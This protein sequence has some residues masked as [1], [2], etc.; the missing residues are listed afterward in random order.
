MPRRIFALLALALSAAST[1]A[2]AAAAA[3]PAPIPRVERIVQHYAD[4]EDFM[5]AVLVAR[6]DEVLF[7]KAYGSANLEL[8]VP[9]TIDTKFRIGSVTKQ[10]TAAA[11]LLLEERGQL[12]VDDPVRK[13]YPD[14]PAAWDKI[15][16]T[17][18]VNH[19][20]GIPN[21]TSLEGFDAFNLAAHTPADIVGF[22]RDKPLEFEPGAEMRYSNSGYILLG[23]IIEKAGGQSYA[24]FLARNIFE[25]LGL[26]GTG[27]DSTTTILP[28]RAAGYV[29]GPN[30]RENAPFGDMSVPYAAGA[31][32]STVGDLHRWNQALYGGQILKPET[33]K[34]MVTPP[35][36]PNPSTYAFGLGIG[37][38]A[39]QTVYEHGGAIDGFNSYLSYF[40]S[41][42]V[43]VVAL[44]NLNGP[45]ANGIAAKLGE[46]MHGKAVVLPT[47]RVA[48][49]LPARKLPEYAGT[50][51][52]APGRDLVIAVLDDHLSVQPGR[53]RAD[54][55]FAE[56]KDR[57]FSR[58]F[59]VQIEFQR[60][61]KGKITGLLL[62]RGD[63]R[64]EARR[65]PG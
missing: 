19:S 2:D 51:E 6:G 55:L 9:N 46:V 38:R 48:I 18:L 13:Y 47:E 43:T 64:R 56:K 1:Q 52:M 57:F 26:K 10:F 41:D 60:D 62:Y 5:G 53:Q 28:N 3:A 12:S 34:R 39:D 30:G 40:P 50:Y 21:F 20:S 37:K 25:P 22:F 31:M 17:H 42:R 16:I 8:N 23:V 44:A 4:L 65:K 27:V 54:P 49:T 61:R 29:P 32:Y 63:D 33:I 7:S 59:D 58:R 36:L 15:T 45:S 24:D 11:I 35:T 14:A